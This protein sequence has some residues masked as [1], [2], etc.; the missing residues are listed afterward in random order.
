[1][2]SF[3]EV[4]NLSVVRTNHGQRP[5]IVSDASFSVQRG[6]CLIVLG[7][8]GGGKTILTRALTRLFPEKNPFRITGEVVFEE[9]RLLDVP[10]EELRKVRRQAIRYVFQEPGKALNPVTTIASQMALADVRNKPGIDRFKEVLADVGIP[11]PTTV[12]RSFPHQ[13]SIGMAQ[14]VMIAMA[15]LPAPAL[16]IADEPTSAVDEETRGTILDLLL[17]RR[18]EGSMA[19]IVTTHDIA[20][21]RALGHRIMVLLRG[22]IVES[23]PADQVLTTPLHP[24]VR[25]FLGVSQEGNGLHKVNAPSPVGRMSDAPDSFSSCCVF[26]GRCAKAKEKCWTLEPQLEGTGTD[27]EV[28]CFF[29]K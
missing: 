15:L 13:L 19:M 8:S 20:V 26:A 25:D 9:R 3:L 29:W 1:M 10:E 16:L 12:L 11:D 21:A 23:G 4:R 24:Y 28:R 6:E 2:P 18:R 7:E 14:R 27:R 17:R 22:M 5:R